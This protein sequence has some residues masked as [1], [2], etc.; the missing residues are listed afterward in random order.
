MQTLS[1]DR[2]DGN[3][4]GNKDK[5]LEVLCALLFMAWT[6]ARLPSDAINYRDA[7]RVFALP[8]GVWWSEMPY[9]VRNG[10]DWLDAGE[11][12]GG[13]FFKK[14]EHDAGVLEGFFFF[15][16]CLRMKEVAQQKDVKENLESLLFLENSSVPFYYFENT[17][18]K[19]RI[20]QLPPT[21]DSLFQKHT[22]TSDKTLMTLD[23]WQVK[24]RLYD[25]K[26]DKARE[27]AI[28]QVQG[29]IMK[30]MGFPY[31]P[32]HSEYLRYIKTNFKYMNICGVKITLRDILD[33][34]FPFSCETGLRGICETHTYIVGR[35]GSGKTVLL[36]GIFK[37]L[38]WIDNNARVVIDPHGDLAD[39]LSCFSKNTYR[40]APHEKRFVINPF[41]IEDKSWENRELV[42]QEITD[43]LAEL[44]EDSGLSRLMTTI[45]FPIVVTLLKLDYADFRMLSD[46]IHPTTGKD[47]LKDLRSLVDEHLKSGWSVLEGDTYES[48]KQSVFNR[49][50]SLLNY[51]LVAQTLCGRDDF[52]KALQLLG[53]VSSP[54]KNTPFGTLIISLPI[55]T[56]GEAVA[57]TLGRFVMTRMQIWAKRR[58]KIP[59][60]DRFPVYLMV[61]E[62]HN[63]ISHSTADTLDQFG[64][65]FGLYM[66][67]AHQ[68][69]Q[70]ITDRE[71]RGSILTNTRSKIAGMSNNETRQAMKKEMGIEAEDM[72]DLKPGH[73]MAKIKEE[74]AIPI[75]VRQLKDYKIIKQPQYIGEQ[76]DSDIVNGWDGFDIEQ[77]TPNTSQKYIKRISRVAKP[78]YDL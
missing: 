47:H 52:T 58:Q 76:K 27:D 25:D 34:F 73:F 55:P 8:S 20:G 60:K 11:Y 6:R 14:V 75:Y 74:P 77:S 41:D 68:H 1:T 24:Q 46:C 3:N 44:V 19:M 50:Q 17:I 21:V 53:D 54:K 65:K 15:I 72:E 61:D 48:S 32:T 2:Y 49:L 38:D 10:R 39:D 64:R 29:E 70:Q 62:F 30:G 31:S 7:L 13:I 12:S 37:M 71:V 33:F 57:V 42:A 78:K 45:M 35:S 5:R 4:G 16:S 40:I 67:L 63:F 26:L 69:I 9:Q 22:P 28:I 23:S 18:C 56:I 51:R 59:E 36:K 43:L 66:I